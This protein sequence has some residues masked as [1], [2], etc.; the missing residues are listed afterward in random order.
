MKK[1]KKIFRRLTLTGGTSYHL[2]NHDL[3]DELEYGGKYIS[4]R[5]V[6]GQV[7]AETSFGRLTL[8]TYFCVVVQY[9]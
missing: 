5:W 4:W 7:A 1:V 2:G 6:I 3:Q 9:M 8:P